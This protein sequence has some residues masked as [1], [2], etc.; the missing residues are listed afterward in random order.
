MRYTDEETEVLRQLYESNTPI[1]DIATQVGKNSRSVIAK[2][3]K[4]G[5]YKKQTYVTKTG[6][7]PRSKEELVGDIASEMGLEV[8]SLPG[9]EKCNKTTLKKLL[10]YIR[11]V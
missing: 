10:D 3:T 7:A 11:Q 6:E 1:E 2:L 8:E 9:L 4:M 5:I